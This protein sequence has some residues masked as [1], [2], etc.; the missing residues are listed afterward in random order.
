[1]CKY[2]RV[3]GETSYVRSVCDHGKY[4][5]HYFYNCWAA[6]CC[7]RML[8]SNLSKISKPISA[9]SLIVCLKAQMIESRISLN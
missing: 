7:S 5:L 6:S 8:I 1:M 4:M 3:I 9:T 2:L